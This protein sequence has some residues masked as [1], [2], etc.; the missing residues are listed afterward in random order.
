MGQI[1]T[2]AKLTAYSLR[3]QVLTTVSLKD[4][5]LLGYSSM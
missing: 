5:S 4:D 2:E 3:F 1:K